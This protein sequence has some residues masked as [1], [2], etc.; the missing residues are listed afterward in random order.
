MLCILVVLFTL[1]VPWVTYGAE[2]AYIFNKDNTCFLIT[3]K[4]LY[5]LKDFIIMNIFLRLLTWFF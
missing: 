2:E 1:T 5:N 3:I 4:A